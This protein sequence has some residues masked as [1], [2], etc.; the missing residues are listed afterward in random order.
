M[1][2]SPLVRIWLV[3]TAGVVEGIHTNTHKHTQTLSHTQT[4][5]RTYVYRATGLLLL[6]GAWGVDRGWPCAGWGLV[7][8]GSDERVH[9]G[10]SGGR[11]K[12]RGGG[13]V[14]WVFRG[15]QAVIGAVV[16]RVIIGIAKRKC[17]STPG[18]SGGGGEVGLG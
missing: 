11:G 14:S 18:G 17:D 9:C 4:D 3:D 15:Q 13:S 10:R 5:L 2:T 7:G 16:G 12:G 6:Q 8:V 1:S